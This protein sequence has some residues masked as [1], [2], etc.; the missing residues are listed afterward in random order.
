AAKWIAP[1]E[2]AKV[3]L[4]RVATDTD[5]RTIDQT[6]VDAVDYHT[7]EVAV[8]ALSEFVKKVRPQTRRCGR[9]VD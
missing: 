9:V 3:G 6:T 7:T 4:V 1:V 5:R 2:A 8:D